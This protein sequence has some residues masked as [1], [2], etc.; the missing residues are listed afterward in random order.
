MTTRLQRRSLAV[1]ALTALTIAAT[2]VTPV[3]AEGS[4]S[5]DAPIV[6]IDGGAVRGEAV[7]GGYAFRGL[8]Y[9]APPTGD[10]RWRAPQRAAQW[11]GVRDATEFSPNCPQPERPGMSDVNDEDCLYLNVY[12]PELDSHR[13]AR[14]PVVVWIHGGGA[15]AGAGRDDVPTKLAAEGTVVVTINYRLGALGFLAHPALASRPGGP[16]GN[17]GL[18]DQQA[19]LRWVRHNIRE[20]GGDPHNVTIMGESSG[21]VHVLAHMVSRG[22][23]GLFDRAIVQSG[24]FA[25]TQLPLA[26]AKDDGEAF[27]A[28]DAVGCSNQTAQCLRDLP[29]DVLVDNF[30]NQAGR[31]TIIDGKVLKESIGTALAAG[32]F[33]RVPI[34][35]GTDH[36][37]ERIF[38]RIGV[39]VSNG[40]FVPL[41]PPQ[42]TTGNYLQQ[43]KATL[44][45]SDERAAAIAAEY[46][47]A[48]Y[49]S[50]TLAFSALVGDANFACTALQQN[51]WTSRRVP[52][53]A[54]EFNDDLAPPRNWPPGFLVPPVATHG[55]ELPYLFDEPDAPFQGPLN[56]DQEGL[57]ASMRAAWASFAATGDPSTAAVPWPSFNEGGQGM[58]LVTPQPQVDTEFA[59]RHHCAFWA[60]S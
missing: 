32:R 36:E 24:S 52:T 43:I 56:P 58:S 30:P 28:L 12:T 23:R 11:R 18:M 25:P 55:S 7:P 16:S 57:A 59:A 19:A 15:T 33:A 34:L 1:A 9:A 8:P 29:V 41:I 20:F 35:N 5:A 60:A 46:P 54:F 10:L 13:G 3:D 37:E 40:T 38:V 49:A 44:D 31:T 6:T 2:D 4:G 17:Y 22:S 47:L 21:G 39:T 45:V 53:F 26:V 42:I 14:R 50:P 48:A 27:A 51:E